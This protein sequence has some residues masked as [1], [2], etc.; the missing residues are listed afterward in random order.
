MFAWVPRLYMVVALKIC[1]A[2][3]FLPL[4]F[5]WP[6]FFGWLILPSVSATMVVDRLIVLLSASWLM[7]VCMTSE[8]IGSCLMDYL[9]VTGWLWSA[10]SVLLSKLRSIWIP[11]GAY[12][13]LFDRKFCC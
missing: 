7:V 11:T 4:C 3:C 1:W 8:V 6:F 13:C 12:F 5:Y 2:G 10:L 9:S